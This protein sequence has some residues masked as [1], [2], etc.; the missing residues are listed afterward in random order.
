LLGRLTE[1]FRST[2]YEGASLARLSQETGLA[3]AA[4]Y[5]RF[6]G[7]KE[8]MARAVLIEVGRDMATAVLKHLD[9]G[10][11]PRRKLTAMCEGLAAFYA[12]GRRSCLA[13]LF[14]I[15]GTPQEVRAP[16]AAGLKAWIAAIARIVEEAGFDPA[17]AARRA[18]DAVVRVEG[19]LVVSR[20]L[21]DTSPFRR[22][23][24]RLPNDLL[25]GAE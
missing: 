22:T 24:E 25:A 3:K 6:A 19:A 4:L 15:E 20:A 13:D 2:G 16:L 11:E 18:E 10:G 17:E 8:E 21:G 23:V 9:G 7:G 12:G 14:S 1:V 5:H